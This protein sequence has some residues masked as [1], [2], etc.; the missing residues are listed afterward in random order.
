MAA[1]MPTAPAANGTAEAQA[2]SA[3]QK[4]L[5]DRTLAH[6]PDAPAP[7][8]LGLMS[9]LA[10]E[11]E[12]ETTMQAV[13]WL[14]QYLEKQ[15]EESA[16]KVQK[17]IQEQQRHL[18]AEALHTALAAAAAANDNATRSAQQ[19]QLSATPANIQQHLAALGAGLP[20]NPGLANPMGRNQPRY[21]GQA[22]RGV[23]HAQS[24]GAYAPGIV[25]G[26][27]MQA[28]AWNPQWM[29]KQHAAPQM[30]Q[31]KTNGAGA[32]TNKQSR[33]PAPTPKALVGGA[34]ETLRTHLRD[35][36]KVEPERV[37]LVRKINR[38]G[39]QSPAVLE[40]H[41][42][43]YGKV[44]RILVAHSHVKSQNRRFAARLRPSGLGFVVMSKK[45]EVE[46]ILLAG[47]EQMVAGIMIRV[48]RFNRYTES[49]EEEDDEDLEEIGDDCGPAAAEVGEAVQ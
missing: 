25:A 35:L 45:C 16:V 30:R 40:S 4:A 29:G 42:S 32:A 34:E 3:L 18:A 38:L 48:Q 27:N 22:G 21:I 44:E 17:L 47:E 31:G 11:K 14:Q 24:H 37:V 5:G 12:P 33:R 23:S 28:P 41:Y 9:K 43:S 2:L 15:Q 39:F 46:A 26:Q 49:L 13:K 20:C 7:Q 10:A 19:Q 6:T 1:A 36:Q 8:A